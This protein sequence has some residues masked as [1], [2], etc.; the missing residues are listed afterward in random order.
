[1]PDHIEMTPNLHDAGF[2]DAI[3]ATF[4]GQAHIAGTGP[5][6]KTCRECR[7][8][9][10]MSRHVPDGPLRPASP[11]YYGKRHPETPLEL[12]RANCNQP[13]PH[14]AKRRVPHEAKACMFFEQSEN[15]PAER[16]ET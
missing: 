1:M 8:W 3:R 15:P 6:G 13:I 9:Y 14:K 5:E 10:V 12:K 11:G 4:L 7:M 16:K 2:E